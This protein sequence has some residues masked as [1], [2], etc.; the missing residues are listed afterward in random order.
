MKITVEIICICVCVPGAL[1]TSSLRERGRSVFWVF[2]AVALKPRRGL[3]VAE[4]S[5]E[6]RGLERRRLSAREDA[7]GGAERF[8]CV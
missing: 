4:R 5:G 2:S 6:A 7:I 1:W 3:E 8:D